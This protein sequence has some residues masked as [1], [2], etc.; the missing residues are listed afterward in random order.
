M[1]PR[2]ELIL[3]CAY[4]RN[5]KLGGLSPKAYEELLAAVRENV[6]AFIDTP[7]EAAFAE[8]VAASETFARELRECEALDDEGYAMGRAKALNKVRASC[9]HALGID[10]TCTDARHMF[11]L[12]TQPGVGSPDQVYSEL[13]ATYRESHA[14]L[15]SLA[16]LPGG[17]TWENV[18]LRPHARLL[19]ALAR[20]CVYST[21]YRLAIAWGEE[22]LELCPNDE[23][24]V[25]HSMAIAYARLED[26]DG[27]NA[28]DDRFDHETTPWSVL[29]RAVLLYRLERYSAA[30]RALLSYV[31]LVEGGAFAMLR[32]VMIPPYL[33]DRPEVARNSF[34]EAMQAV[35]E[36]ETVLADE[37]GFTWW[38]QNLPGVEES[39][40]RFAEDNGFEWD[41]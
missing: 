30:R 23:V 17:L 10:P 22:L 13:L 7:E 32:P 2:E 11:L 14:Q 25:R 34:E 33:P 37:P 1:N 19:A 35:Y 20:H 28:L 27:L 31:R 26:E 6:S 4:R 18:F 12:A 39:G 36:I 8:V 15:D 29:S 38:A 9:K 24:G 16:A 5:E 40:K 21:R 41:Q 3:R